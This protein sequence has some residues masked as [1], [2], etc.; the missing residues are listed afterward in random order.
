MK[1]LPK[2]IE[3]IIDNDPKDYE[4]NKSLTSKN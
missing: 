2:N 3:I 1:N 4:A